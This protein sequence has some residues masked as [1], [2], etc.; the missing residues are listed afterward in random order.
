VDSLQKMQGMMGAMGKQRE[1]LSKVLSK[2]KGQIPAPNAPPGG[3]GDDDD[4]GGVQPDS[5]AGQ[6]ENAS[7]EGDQMPLSLSPDQAGQ[8]LDGLSLDGGRRLSM[9]DKQGAPPRDRT[10]RNW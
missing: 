8:I 5:L 3:T 7:R 2:L 4:E 9:S 10:G 1:D 6:K